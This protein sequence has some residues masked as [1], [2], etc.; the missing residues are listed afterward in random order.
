MVLD[1]ILNIL[2]CVLIVGGTVAGMK[3][4]FVSIAA[5]PIK[6]FASIA[7][8]ISICGFVGDTIIHGIIEAP[9]TNYVSD[10]LYNN[11]PGLNESNVSE[12][13]PTLLKMAAGLAGLNIEEIAGGAAVTG[14]DVINALAENL[15]APAVDMFSVI[16]AFVLVYF[17]SK[18][19]L[20]VVLWV[21]DMFFQGG[22]IGLLNKILGTAVG[23][24][25]A[26]IAAWALV[27]LLEF[28]FHLPGIVETEAIAEFEGGFL[29][30]FLKTYNPIEL[31][32][33][34]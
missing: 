15:T 17:V 31:L 25:L 9:I 1:I 10:F 34:F 7:I 3:L 23:F 24:C 32:L 18:L 20:T 2:L 12:E 8:A 27:A 5:K 26:F 28:V 21:I 30:G 14:K 16:I 4:G 13:L 33:S 11:C 6:F 29:Y 19:I 22:L